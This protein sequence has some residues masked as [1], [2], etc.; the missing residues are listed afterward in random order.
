MCLRE[1]ECVYERVCV[2]VRE[3]MCVCVCERQKELEFNEW[4]LWESGAEQS[5]VSECVCVRESVCER[6]CV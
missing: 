5:E 6:E 3:R 2:C 4:C 1:R